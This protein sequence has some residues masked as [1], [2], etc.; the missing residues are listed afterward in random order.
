MLPQIHNGLAISRVEA[1]G[2]RQ[3]SRRMAIKGRSYYMV[4]TGQAGSTHYCVEYR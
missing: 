3:T 2:I 4:R 1:D